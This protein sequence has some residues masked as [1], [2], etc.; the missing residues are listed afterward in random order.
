MLNFLTKL[1]KLQA[2][3]VFLGLAENALGVVKGDPLHGDVILFPGVALVL[4]RNNHFG[5]FGLGGI[6]MHFLEN[7]HSFGF[8]E[9]LLPFGS[10]GSVEI[11]NTHPMWEDL[12]ILDPGLLLGLS[13]KGHFLGR[14]FFDVAFGKIIVPARIMEE[15]VLSLAVDHPEHHGPD[16]RLPHGWKAKKTQK[17]IERPMNRKFHIF[18]DRWV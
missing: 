7:P 5:R 9:S 3:Q 17:V 1:M 4:M 6:K 8:A 16:G 13:T 11:T 18:I 15:E 2:L 12:E 14:P 10:L